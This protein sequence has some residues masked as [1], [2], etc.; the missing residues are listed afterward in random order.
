MLTLGARGHT[1]EELSQLLGSKPWPASSASHQEMD[2]LTGALLASNTQP[3]AE[4]QIGHFVQVANALFLHNQYSM[5]PSYK[6]VVQSVYRA[7]T[8]NVDFTSPVAVQEQANK[9]VEEKTRGKIPQIIS[10]PLHP[11]T[12]LLIASTIYFNARWKT[13][14]LEGMTKPRPFWLEGRDKEPVRVE[15]MALGGHF[16]F[17]ESPE[18]NCRMIALPY[19]NS[20]ST[21]FILLPNNST[22]TAVRNLHRQLSANLINQMIARMTV[23]SSIVFL[24]KMHLTSTLNLEREISALGVRSLFDQQ[25]ADLGLLAEAN[26]V[27]GGHGAGAVHS[28][29][30]VHTQVHHQPHTQ[31]LEE[32]LIFSRFSEDKAASGE[33]LKS[34]PKRSSYKVT[35][36]DGKNQD[37]LGMKDFVL[38]KRITKENKINKK[39][40]G[41]R[42]RRQVPDLSAAFQSLDNGR[43]QSGRNPGLFANE[44]VHK[45]DLVINEKGTEGGA[46]KN[47]A[48][49]NTLA[50]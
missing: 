26:N 1:Y 21:M 32:V 33:E 14:F 7:E 50:V 37:P 9:W 19:R 6:Q 2:R 25:S 36:L 38:R 29:A 15:M 17:Y 30:P 4:N 8:F 11:Q 48:S 39:L 42:H 27:A 41:H 28:F 20:A 45:V 22:V 47:E 18:L 35:S 46:G 31:N 24:P 12:R 40:V 3:D 43:S 5:N 23:A 49:L 10:S 34:R 16:P 44:I 13:T